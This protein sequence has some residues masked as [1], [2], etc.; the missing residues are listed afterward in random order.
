MFFP[1]FFGGA[2]FPFL[3]SQRL[4]YFTETKIH[5]ATIPNSFLLICADAGGWKAS[6]IRPCGWSLQ[7]R[8]VQLIRYC[9]DLIIDCSSKSCSIL[10]EFEVAKRTKQITYKY[11]EIHQHHFEVKI[12]W[13]PKA[14]VPF[15]IDFW[16]EESESCKLTVMGTLEPEARQ[17]SRHLHLGVHG[18]D[19]EFEAPNLSVNWGCNLQCQ[20]GSARALGAFCTFRILFAL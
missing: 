15:A 12:Q 16:Y 1:A 5:D 2:S 17:K 9:V 11:T 8:Q 7:I 4:R 18:G 20:F 13:W 14:K 6:R 10:V 3:V 19:R